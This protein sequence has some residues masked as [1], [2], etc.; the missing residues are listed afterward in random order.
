MKKVKSFDYKVLSAFISKSHDNI[1]L[2]EDGDL[3]I[4]K[5]S[6]IPIMDLVS[7]GSSISKTKVID[8]FIEP[9][10]ESV[11]VLKNTE[12]TPKNEEII[13][14]IPEVKQTSLDDFYQ[15]FKL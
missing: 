11:E 14:I 8:A 9:S 6:D 15:D 13:E 4:I 10:Y 1:I 3:K 12:N 5:S 2:N 7:T